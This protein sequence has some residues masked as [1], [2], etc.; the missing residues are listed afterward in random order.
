MYWQSTIQYA[1][2]YMHSTHVLRTYLVIHAVVLC[3]V[4]AQ[5]ADDDHGEDAGQEEDDDHR[6]DDGE[7]VDLHV[8]HRQVRVPARRP[9]DV[10][11][12]PLHL[13]REPHRRFSF[14]RRQNTLHVL[15]TG[16][17]K[18]FKFNLNFGW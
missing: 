8:A 14:K 12:L 6:V 2:K 1:L 16:I 4:L 17:L 3:D 7:P 11:R 10:A 5:R 15:H 18:L 9:L 13:V